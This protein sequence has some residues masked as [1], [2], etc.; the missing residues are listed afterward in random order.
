MPACQQMFNIFHPF[1]PV[2]YRSVIAPLSHFRWTFL[3]LFCLVNRY[4]GLW[5][6]SIW[7][8]GRTFNQLIFVIFD[9]FDTLNF[10]FWFL[11][12]FIYLFII[13]SYC[14]LDVFFSHPQL[15]PNEWF[16]YNYSWLYLLKRKGKM[17]HAGHD[18]AYLKG[19][20]W[21]TGH[22]CQWVPT[23]TARNQMGKPPL[24]TIPLP[25]FCWVHTHTCAH[26]PHP[27]LFTLHKKK[28]IKT[29][30]YTSAIWFIIVLLFPS[31]VSGKCG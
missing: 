4:C 12:F 31:H 7:T 24:S 10:K 27:L 15:P 2:A 19:E 21:Q 11:I 17:V 30:W 16:F 9:L 14:K 28:D 20:T 23:K 22:S 18:F 26:T 13:D 29:W 3:F 6:W 8:A 25:F 1:D 5:S